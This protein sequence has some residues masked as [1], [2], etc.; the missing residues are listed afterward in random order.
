MGEPYAYMLDND[1]CQEIASWQG[2]YTP[3]PP[4]TAAA[5]S[6]PAS[7][8]HPKQSKGLMMLGD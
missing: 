5:L 2:S 1:G 7:Q 3:G 6:L 4:K 8:Q